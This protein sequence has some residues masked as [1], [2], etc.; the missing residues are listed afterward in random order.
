[1]VGLP[2]GIAEELV[3]LAAIVPLIASNVSTPYSC[4]VF[5]SDA[6]LASGAVVSAEV[7]EEVVRCLW[8]GSNKK[9]HYTK[10]E[11]T[12]AAALRAVGEGDEAV[13]EDLVAGPR[14]IY[15]AP[16][17]YFDFVEVCGG[18]GVLSREVAALGLVVAPV[19][20]LSYSEFYD[21]GSLRFLEWSLH[22]VSSGRF[23]SF[24]IAPPCTTFSPAAHPSCRSYSV[25]YDRTD[26]KTFHGNLLAFR[27]FTMLR[28]G[29][30]ARRPCGLEQP[31]RS[32]MCWTPMWRS[33]VGN[34]FFEAVLASCQFG[35]IQ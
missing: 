33:L 3:S 28:A 11:N 18:S 5:A 4:E 22:M 35:S 1:M 26:G 12:F 16:L 13:G 29:R 7:E 25:G 24:F 8:L 31:R 6:S 21:L 2:R 27:A 20:D 14:H 23:R 10:L 15:K 9:G 19:L 34:E 30:R 32:K 17:L